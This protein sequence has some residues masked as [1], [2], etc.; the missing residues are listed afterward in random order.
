MRVWF[1]VNSIYLMSS[2]P[3]SDSAVKDVNARRMFNGLP[4]SRG[5]V[6]GPV[7]LYRSTGGE[8]IPKYRIDAQQVASEGARLTNAFALTK[9]QINSLAKELKKRISGDE[10]TIFDGHLMMLED[11][12]FMGAC[13]DKIKEDLCNAEVAVNAVSEQYFSIFEAMDDVYLRERAKD[14]N[15]IAKKI[16]KNLS[17]RSEVTTSHIKRP[18]IIVADELSPS[19]TISLPRNMILGFATDRGSAFSHAAL[20]SRALGIPAVAGLNSIS[21]SVKTG[22]FLLLDGT[23]GKVVVNPDNKERS[24]FNKMVERSKSIEAGLEQDK[25][26]KGMTADGHPVPFLANIDHSTPLT[27]FYAAGAEG[28]GLY[29]SEYLWMA[30]ER[31]PTEEEQANAY[32]AAARAMPEGHAVTIRVFDLGGDK[33]T[34]D[35]ASHKEANPFLGN[36]SIRYLLRNR[37]VFRRQLRAI[38]RASA[39]GSV[40]V[41]YPMIATVEELR[42]SNIELRSCMTELRGKG[43]PFDEN[44]RRGVMIEVPAAALIAEVLAKNADFFSIGTND[45]IQYSLAVDRVNETVARLYQPTHAGVLHLI[46]ISIKAAHRQGLKVAVC[47]EVAA[48][49]YLAVLLI[50]MGIDELSMSPNL[51]PIVKKVVRGVTLEDARLLAEEVR[52]MSAQPAGKSYEHCRNFVIKAMPDLMCIQ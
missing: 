9:A 24:A 37:E 2:D 39:H 14:I 36:R 12:A 44:I 29:R 21:S 23:R 7:F 25:T 13:L 42:A 27:E 3:D 18:S 20:L 38:L 52:N 10:A 47:G 8:Q 50:G 15:D 11:A 16:I 22:D 40:Q 34:Q 30:Y 6:S 5:F 45:L 49:P 48:D 1:R 31:E 33:M 4:V 32:T 51:M 26:W 17:G 19:E 28:V 43:I 41:M 35:I 46:D